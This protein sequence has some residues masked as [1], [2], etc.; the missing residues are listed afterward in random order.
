MSEPAPS[1]EMQAK[2]AM[3][4]Q[5]AAALSALGG[6]MR[7]QQD[8]AVDVC[9]LGSR[10]EEIAR[11]ARK[12]AYSP[13][14]DP[15]EGLRDLSGALDEFAEEMRATAARVE[16]ETL[17]GRAVAEALSRHSADLDALAHRPGETLDMGTIRASLRPLATTLAGLPAQMRAGKSRTADV[18]ALAARAVEMANRAT[19]LLSGNLVGRQE[20][21][22]ALARGLGELAEQAVQVSARYSDDAAVAVRVAEEMAGRATNLSRG[23]PHDGMSASLS[24]VLSTGHALAGQAQADAPPAGA[25]A[26]MNWDFGRKDPPP[27]ARAEPPKLRRWR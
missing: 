11:G 7:A 23:R 9:A 21:M 2:Q 25:G 19:E 18:A 22:L 1:P 12:L 3:L 5:L 24:E 20:Q 13:R 15:H 10:A 6:K 27:G 16:Q 4:A 17:L 26:A 14:H 8:A